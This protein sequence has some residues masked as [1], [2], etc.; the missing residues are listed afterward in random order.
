MRPISAQ[1]Y[2]GIAYVHLDNLPIDQQ[3]QLDEWMPATEF[4]KIKTAERV[5]DHCVS[6]R[7]YL[8]WFE[9]FYAE[10]GELNVQI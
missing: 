4:I 6:Y 8:H 3:S 1:N 5:I 10:E 2:R 7:D 9:N